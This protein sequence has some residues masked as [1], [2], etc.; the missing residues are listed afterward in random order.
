MLTLTSAVTGG[1]FALLAVGLCLAPRM[2]WG[3]KW[4]GFA[5]AL[6]GGPALLGWAVEFDLDDPARRAEVLFQA[7]LFNLATLGGVAGLA[8]LDGRTRP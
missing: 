3:A 7:G 8:W 6:T 2:R 5:A 4:A 1:L